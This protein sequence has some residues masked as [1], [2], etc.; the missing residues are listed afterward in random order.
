MFCCCADRKIVRR[1][2]RRQVDESQCPSASG[3]DSSDTGDSVVPRR[4]V[5]SFI[6]RGPAQSAS[7]ISSSPSYRSQGSVFRSCANVEAASGE[8]IGVVSDSSSLTVRKKTTIVHRMSF[9]AAGDVD[10][11]SRMPSATTVIGRRS[12]FENS[13]DEMLPRASRRSSLKRQSYRMDNTVEIV[14]EQ[15][16]F[17][18]GSSIASL[19]A[20]YEA[21]SPAHAEFFDDP[22]E[23]S[24]AIAPPQALVGVEPVGTQEGKRQSHVNIAGQADTEF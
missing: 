22:F 4:S 7:M 14:S 18:I 1:P 19:D 3:K 8:D 16:R 12:S 23:K 5:A 2:S 15:R 11:C 21:L 17:S 6:S 13:F 20:T 24:E 10:D 9:S